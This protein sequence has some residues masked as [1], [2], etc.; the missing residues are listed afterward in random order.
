MTKRRLRYDDLSRSVQQELLKLARKA[1]YYAD[2]VDLSSRWSENYERLG[3]GQSLG[4]SRAF[5]GLYK[6]LRGT[7]ASKK[8]HRRLEELAE[9]YH[10]TGVNYDEFPRIIRHNLPFSVRDTFHGGY[11]D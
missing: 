11:E 8:L 1:Q 9:G 7:L 4:A 3:L 6:G 5:I 2:E 10:Y